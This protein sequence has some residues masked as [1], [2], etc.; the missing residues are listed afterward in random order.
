MM[1]MFIITEATPLKQR[2]CNCG[3]Y[4]IPASTGNYA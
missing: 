2:T 3:R 4:R 1:M